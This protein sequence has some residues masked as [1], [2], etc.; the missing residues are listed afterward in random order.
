[1][2]KRVKISK[3]TADVL[4]QTAKEK[5]I[6]VDNLI[7]LLAGVT[8]SDLLLTSVTHSKNAQCNTLKRM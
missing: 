3:K 6:S 8:H 7:F 1:M 2:K 5:N 4:Q